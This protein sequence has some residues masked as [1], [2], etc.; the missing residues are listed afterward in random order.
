MVS[1]LSILKKSGLRPIAKHCAHC[2]LLSIFS[3]LCLNLSDKCRFVRAFAKVTPASHRV[4]LTTKK[5]LH[6]LI[7]GKARVL[8][9]RIITFPY[10]KMDPTPSDVSSNHYTET[11]IEGQGFSHQPVKFPNKVREGK[12]G[13]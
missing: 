4:S 1:F 2:K 12:N 11:K 9:L 10:L 3:T 13:F 5:K 8:L 6:S 7:A